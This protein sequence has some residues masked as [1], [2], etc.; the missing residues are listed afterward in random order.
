VQSAVEYLRGAGPKP[1]T[2]TL[3]QAGG[4]PN[5]GGMMTWS[6]NWDKVTTCNPTSYEYAQNYHLLF[7]S[8]LGINN[9]EKLND[10]KLHQNYPNPFNPSTSIGYEIP[11]SGNVKLIILDALGREVET[12]VNENQSSGSYSIEWD[13]SQYS[14]GVYFCRLETKNFTDVKRMLLVR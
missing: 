9:P 10:Y 8:P 5:I 7:G 12:L 2:Y 13:A 3:Y 1:G 14:S 11:E 4:Y 6:V